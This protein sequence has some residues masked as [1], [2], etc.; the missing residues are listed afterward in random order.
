MTDKE[1]SDYLEAKRASVVHLSHYAVM[2]PSRPIFP[3]DMQRAIEKRQEF[4]LSCVVVWPGHGMSL[5][6]SVG[7]IFKPSFSQVISVSNSDSGSTRLL[8]GRD[9]SLGLPLTHE[10]LAA[11]FDVRQGDY[12]EWRVQGAEVVGIFIGNQANIQV[13]KHFEIEQY[14]QKF[15]GVA[16]KQVE[17]K[18]VFA[19]FP[20]HSFF[21]MGPDGLI[22]L[23]R[24]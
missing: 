20:N 9:G 4:P 21:T 24:P 19:A 1:L 23:L 3:E 16:P 6:G 11:T 14:G 5:P 13:K 18:D 2:D 15:S 17:L 12:N 7:V 10:S 22:E 8:D